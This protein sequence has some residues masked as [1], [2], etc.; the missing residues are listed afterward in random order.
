MT[1]P[2]LPGKRRAAAIA[3]ACAAAASLGYA[4]A[5]P[6]VTVT[7]PLEAVQR[8]VSSRMPLAGTKD[9]ISYEVTNPVARFS[10]DGSVV[11]RAEAV[12]SVPGRT[13]DASIE[14]SARLAYSAGGF[15]LERPRPGPWKPLAVDPALGA[16]QAPSA[17][18]SAAVDALGL[19]DREARA[20][21]AAGDAARFL[22]AGRDA[23]AGEAAAKGGAML[24]VALDGL[25]ARA[26][27]AGADLA[28][29]EVRAVGTDLEAD[30][31]DVGPWTRGALVSLGLLMA[32]AACAAFLPSVPAALA[33]VASRLTRP[34]SRRVRTGT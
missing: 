31:N 23:V 21:S 19:R 26:G 3:L 2:P 30:L 29:R 12:A 18:L 9:D 1:L 32:A 17:G 25:P 13:A 22:V 28:L 14:V 27:D 16:D 6:T 24:S 5:H 15:R 8:A 33:G 7:V 11:V 20:M 34:A 10:P 4:A